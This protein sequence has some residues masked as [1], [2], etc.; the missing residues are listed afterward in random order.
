MTNYI[1]LAVAGERYAA[2]LASNVE[3]VMLDEHERH[4]IRD[5]NGRVRQLDDHESLYATE[6]EALAAGAR[7]LRSIAATALAKADEVEA[8][9]AATKPEVIA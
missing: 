4:I 7:S 6:A 8:G 2:V 3:I 5:A 9:L 1:P